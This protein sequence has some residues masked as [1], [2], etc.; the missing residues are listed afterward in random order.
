MSSNTYYK[1]KVTGGSLKLRATPNGSQ[2][3]IIPNNKVLPLLSNGSGWAH[4]F[5]G[6]KEGYVNENYITNQGSIEYWQYLYG[7]KNLYRGC[8]SSLFVKHLQ[9]RLVALN[10]LS[11]SG[12]NACDGVFGLNTEN[13][14][15]AFQNLCSLN[16]DG[17]VGNN[18][19]E[20]L[21]PS[22]PW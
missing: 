4:T 13:A 9:E 18:T 16:P 2:V 8:S 14:V 21:D 3:A 5:Y 17:I 10:L 19:K 12:G 7:L 22:S 15:I 1:G 11:N 20:A 6:M